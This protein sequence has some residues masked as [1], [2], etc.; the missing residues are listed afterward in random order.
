[1]AQRTHGI[2]HY[3]GWMTFLSTSKGLLPNTLRLY[4]RCIEGLA[5]DHPDKD[6]ASLVP[7]ELETWL[8]NKG[9]SASSYSNRLS[10]LRSFYRF[11]VRREIRMDD[12]TINIE[13]PKRRKG[14][15]KPVREIAKVL[16]KLDFEDQR[17]NERT[18]YNKQRRVG[19]TRDM[20][21][22]IAGT[23]MRISEACSVDLPVPA[24]DEFTIIG[25]GAKERPVFLAIPESKAA[26]ERLGGS[27]DIGPRAIQRRFERADFHPHQLRHWLATE[28]INQGV[29]LGTVSK[30]LGHSSTATT[31]VYAEYASDIMKS[32]LGKVHIEV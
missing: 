6:V 3:D 19:E 20:A 5:Q 4:G 28:L 31:Q 24:P 29:E 11:L 1:M 7:V 9:G 8:Q 23:G 12:P 26:I 2:V 32:A 27:I 21:M 18:G 16:D 10:A 13:A 25:K 30:I 22:F 14:L 17:S 15:P